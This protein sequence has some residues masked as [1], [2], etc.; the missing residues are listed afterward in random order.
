MRSLCPDI[1]TLHL[2]PWNMD[3]ID[4]ENSEQ[5]T[6][7]KTHV[8]I[9]K[10][11][12]EWVEKITAAGLKGMVLKEN[13][14]LYQLESRL[15]TTLE[16]SASHTDVTSIAKKIF[17]NFFKANEIR[18]QRIAQKIV[19]WGYQNGS[20]MVAKRIQVILRIKSDGL[21]GPVTIHAINSVHQR[22]FLE[23][24]EEDQKK[25]RKGINFLGNGKLNFF[26]AW[27]L[28]KGGYIPG[29]RKAALAIIIAAGLVCAAG[30]YYIHDTRKK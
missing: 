17:R 16:G 9:L 26:K 21:F 24:I 28:M 8:H 18:N 7:I 25:Y 2:T 12:K 29:K 14:V 27:Q 22:I 19:E 5:K 13:E 4:N 11:S 30:I 15:H 3:P 20:V 6:T 23:A 1:G 10:G